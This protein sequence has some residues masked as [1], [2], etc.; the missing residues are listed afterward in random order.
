MQER[1]EQEIE[2]LHQRYPQMEKN[3]NWIRIPNYPLPEGWNRTTTDVALQ[4]P[5]QY[6]GTPPYGIYTPG[7]LLFRGAS[8]DNYTAASTQ[9]PFSGTW[10]VFSWAPVDGQWRATS[11]PRTGSNL[12]NW[13]IGFAQRFKEGK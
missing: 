13:V 9:V 8:P 3:G 7:G 2:M 4:I 11:D 5:P 12:L 10:Y 6:P 1:I